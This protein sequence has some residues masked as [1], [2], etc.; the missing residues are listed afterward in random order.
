MRLFLL[1]ATLALLPSCSARD[2]IEM[3]HDVAGETKRERLIRESNAD[4]WKSRY[5]LDSERLGSP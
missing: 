2:L 5:E 1:L 4:A 3:G